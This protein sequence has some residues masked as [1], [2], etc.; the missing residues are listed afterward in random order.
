MDVPSRKA[1]QV[2]AL[3]WPFSLYVLLTSGLVGIDHSLA[4]PSDE[5]V[6]AITKE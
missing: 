2:T 3:V 5:A 4:T 1:R 6:I